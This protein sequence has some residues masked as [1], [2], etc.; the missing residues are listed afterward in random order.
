MENDQSIRLALEADDPTNWKDFS[1]ETPSGKG[2][3]PSKRSSDY[4]N[5]DL[6]ID[7]N[8][9]I[10]V[11]GTI[12]YLVGEASDTWGKFDIWK[13]KYVVPITKINNPRQRQ[14]EDIVHSISQSA[15]PLGRTAALNIDEDHG[16][17]LVAWSPSDDQSISSVSYAL[18]RKQYRKDKVN[19]KEIQLN[20]IST[21][22]AVNP[23]ENNKI[24]SGL[25]NR[26]VKIEKLIKGS[27]A[28]SGVATGLAKLTLSTYIN[29][30]NLQTDYYTETIATIRQFN[31]F[32]TTIKES[33]M[34]Q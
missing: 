24:I 6:D 27:F 5:L 22:Y 9:Y 29:E 15:Q 7:A 14:I 33:F 19:G 21:L 20:E 2:G 11:G 1:V 31:S 12:R 4:Y 8:I 23:I 30:N 25:T 34:C 26:T 16:R 3:Y 28:E 17:I 32:I 13:K 18:S 10:T